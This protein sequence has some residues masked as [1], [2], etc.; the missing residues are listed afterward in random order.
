MRQTGRR[1]TRRRRSRRRTT[2]YPA[3]ATPLPEANPATW[4]LRRVRSEPRRRTVRKLANYVRPVARLRELADR[5]APN[6]LLECS[7]TK[8][9]ATPL[10]ATQ[11]GGCKSCS[12]AANR[13][14]RTCLLQSTTAKYRRAFATATKGAITYPSPRLAGCTM[15]SARA[16]APA[17]QIRKTRHAASCTIH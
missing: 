1:S 6:A 8:A 16:R 2:K 12:A 9:L 3:R 4:M 14:S 10:I 13:A 15:N 17:Q 11:T 5:H 7:K